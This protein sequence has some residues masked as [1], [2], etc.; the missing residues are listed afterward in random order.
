MQLF[1]IKSVKYEKGHLQSF[2]GVEKQETTQT[3]DNQ[4]STISREN[5]HTASIWGKRIQKSCIFQF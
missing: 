4:W 2:A 3:I 1:V 5:L